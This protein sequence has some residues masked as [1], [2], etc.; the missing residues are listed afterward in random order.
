M[1]LMQK[2]VNKSCRPRTQRSDSQERNGSWLLQLILWHWGYLYLYLLLRSERRWKVIFCLYYDPVI[3]PTTVWSKVSQ[4]TNAMITVLTTAVTSHN[5]TKQNETDLNLIDRKFSMLWRGSFNAVELCFKSLK[6]EVLHDKY[7]LWHKI[8]F[9]K[10][11]EHALRV[12]F[13]DAIGIQIQVR[14]L[15]SGTGVQD[16]GSILGSGILIYLNFLNNFLNF[17]GDSG[18]IGILSRW[19]HSRAEYVQFMCY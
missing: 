4:S 9:I 12:I 1:L 11:F 8:P 7:F 19:D 3:F 6:T 2:R 18:L 17:D 16:S 5:E 14:S 10:Y 13:R 15:G